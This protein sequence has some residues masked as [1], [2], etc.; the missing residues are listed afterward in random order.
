MNKFKI[1]GSYCICR[2]Q[3]KSIEKYESI[4][5]FRIQSGE[6]WETQGKS[7]DTTYN[8]IPRKR[9]RVH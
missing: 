8:S 2:Q 4:H 6:L 7:A 5:H 9:D 1:N 3:P